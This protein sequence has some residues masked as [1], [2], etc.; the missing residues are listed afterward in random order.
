MILQ[1]LPFIVP[2]DAEAVLARVMT[3]SSPGRRMEYLGALASA[4]SPARRAEVLE[5]AVRLCL[6]GAWQ[7]RQAQLKALARLIPLLQGAERRRVIDA[8]MVAAQTIGDQETA[9]AALASCLPHVQAPLRTEFAELIAQRSV[10]TSTLIQARAAVHPGT[11]DLDA[12]LADVRNI[13]E[14][15]VGTLNACLDLASRAP[16]EA[17]SLV[18]ETAWSVAV[19]L[20]DTGE[21]RAMPLLVRRAADEW[22]TIVAVRLLE[23]YDSYRAFRNEGNLHK[24]AVAGILAGLGAALPSLDSEMRGQVLERVLATRDYLLKIW[25][26]DNL[27]GLRAFLVPFRE[28]GQPLF[29]RDRVINADPYGAPRH[30]LRPM[31]LAEIWTTL[32][33]EVAAELR[34]PE[35]TALFAARKLLQ[36]LAAILASEPAT[37]ALDRGALYAHWRTILVRARATTRLPVLAAVAELPAVHRALGGDGAVDQGLTAM[38]DVVRWWP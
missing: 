10:E 30:V 38:R 19:K 36:V 13:Q 22:R 28:R 15:S 18:M 2:G 31:E 25:R 12:L 34:G 16:D 33:A 23:C 20:A 14:P 1:I 8:V 29:N 24:V 11:G 4:L 9:A 37:E 27:Q 21:L 32:L 7:S 35:L 26:P 17:R 3:V 5:E 6:E